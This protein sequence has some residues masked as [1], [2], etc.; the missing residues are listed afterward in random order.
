[1][2]VQSVTHLTVVQEEAD[3][4]G[5]GEGWFVLQSLFPLLLL[6]P[7]WRMGF[8]GCCHKE[9]PPRQPVRQHGNAIWG[10]RD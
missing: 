7:S 2:A 3:D 6:W 8:N 4:G 5:V 9:W 10:S 1:M